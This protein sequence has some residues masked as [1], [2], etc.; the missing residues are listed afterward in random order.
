MFVIIKLEM[1]RAIIL[2]YKEYDVKSLKEIQKEELLKSY[3]VG[4]FKGELFYQF[5]TQ[6]RFL[7]N[8]SPEN[9]HYEIFRQWFTQIDRGA[10]IV[11]YI[12]KK[13]QFQLRKNIHLNRL[14]KEGYLR[15]RRGYD[16]GKCNQSYLQLNS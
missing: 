13:H 6:L 14:W 2:F 15:L 3:Q 1:K 11:L 8:N 9:M 16:G 7:L 12:N 4:V 10:P 5:M